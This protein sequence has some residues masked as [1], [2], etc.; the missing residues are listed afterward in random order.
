[1]NFLEILK[2]LYF[3]R[4]YN[5]MKL[6]LFRIEGLLS[7][8]GNPHSGAKYFHITGSNGKGSVTTFLEYLTYSHGYSVTGF[9]SPHLSTILERFH[10]N[11]QNISEEKFVEAALQVKKIAEDMDRLGEEFAPSFFEYMTAMYFYITNSLKVDYGSVEVGL[12]GRFD[13]TN[14]IIPE[15]SVITTV[16]L[17]HTNVLG[18]S[19]EEIAFEKAGI[20]KENRPVVLGLMP[21]SA[22]EVIRDIAKRFN[23]KVYEF[24]KDFTVEPVSYAFNE[25]IYNYYGESTIKNIKVKL[26]GTHQLYNIGVAL[27]AYELTNKLNEENVK[28]AFENAFI[29]GRF[30]MVDG[31]ILDGSHNPQAAENFA[32]NID[33]YF[34]GKKRAAVFGIV[35]D[36]DKDAVLKAIAPKFDTIIITRP[37]SKRAVKIEQTFEIAKRYCKQVILEPDIINAVNMLKSTDC[38]LRFATGSFY[39]V[40]YIR[41]YL[42]SGKV[43]EELKLGGA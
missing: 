25:N 33:L 37:P 39:L 9:Y 15:V 22:S 19:I 2:Y 21:I 29:P 24:G 35:D 1:M 4:P 11:T 7:R 36:K 41:D 27:K 5:T 30:E 26:N 40:G 20:I 28:N 32:K 38:D 31:I 3:T 13:S 8:M 42:I 6:G 23:A 14:V 43:N 16:S 34:S 18:N 12:G 10:Y 17:E